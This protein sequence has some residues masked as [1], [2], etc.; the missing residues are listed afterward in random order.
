MEFGLQQ[1]PEQHHDRLPSTSQSTIAFLHCII[2]PF[3]FFKIAFTLAMNGDINKKVS[4]FYCTTIAIS[5][6]GH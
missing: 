5:D 1:N 2:R 3:S 6:A 4:V